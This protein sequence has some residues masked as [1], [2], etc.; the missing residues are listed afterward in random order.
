MRLEAAREETQFYEYCELESKSLGSPRA[1]LM[2]QD[3]TT[4]TQEDE[5]LVN[6]ANFEN[7][8]SFFDDECE[9]SLSP[10]F[11]GLDIIK[12]SNLAF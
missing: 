4:T 2:S 3:T 11:F 8:L 5:Y 10:E 7:P 9:R 12:S 1:R 6:Y